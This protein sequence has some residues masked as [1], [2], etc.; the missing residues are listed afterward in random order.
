MYMHITLLYSL[1][2]L[3]LF[4]FAFTLKSKILTCLFYSIREHCVYFNFSN[5]FKKYIY[6]NN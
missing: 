4:N 5:N 2:M 1:F 3:L 6:M